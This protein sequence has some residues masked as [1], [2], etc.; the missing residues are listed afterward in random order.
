SWYVLSAMGIYPVTPGNPIY[1]IGSPLFGEITLHLAKNKTFSIKAI[2]NSKENK[3]IQSAT[4]NKH[5]FNQTWISQ[6]EI[7]KG[8]EL[9]FVMGSKPN[10]NWGTTDFPPSMS[11]KQ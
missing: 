7:T 10:K 9:V 2:N 4:L 5:T 6:K 1:A 3:Y 8:G 11:L